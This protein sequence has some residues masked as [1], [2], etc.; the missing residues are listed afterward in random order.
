MK[1]V[2]ILW[3]HFCSPGLWSDVGRGEKG[4]SGQAAAVGS[5]VCMGTCIYLLHPLHMGEI[6][7]E[8][9]PCKVVQ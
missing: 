3:P 8:R 7:G 9:M 4:A 5:S 6:M 2:G 1:A